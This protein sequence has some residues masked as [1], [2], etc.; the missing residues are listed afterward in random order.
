MVV[1]GGGLKE[2]QVGVGG[3]WYVKWAEV[4]VGGR[5]DGGGRVGL[6]VVEEGGLVPSASVD[7]E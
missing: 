2:K 3:G 7:R 5:N 4:V 6:V 1:G